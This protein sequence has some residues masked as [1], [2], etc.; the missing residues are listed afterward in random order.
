MTDALE[1]AGQKTLADLGKIDD[2]VERYHETRTQRARVAEID[3]ALKGIERGIALTLKDG[4]TWRQ[5]GE[6]LGV[7]GSRAEQISRGR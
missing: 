2:L 4:R 5:V 7:S 3:R 1:A 6:L